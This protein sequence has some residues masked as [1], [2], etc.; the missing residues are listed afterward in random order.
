MDFGKGFLRHHH[1]EDGSARGDVP[2]ALPDAVGGGHA[3]ARVSLGRAHGRAC[4]Q[5]PAGIQELRSLGGQAPCLF[6]RAEHPGQDI[7]QLPAELLLRHQ[8]VELLYHPGV[9]VTGL[10]IDWEH[11]GGLAHAQHL[12]PRQPPV[13]V[14][15]QG[16]KERHVLHMLLPVQDG[17]IE[18]GDAPSLGNV[19]IEFLQQLPA[20][21]PGHGI[22]PGP[23]GHQQL[24]RRVKGHIAVHHTRK[25][26]GS[27]L[28]QPHP[29]FR[30]HVLRKAPVAALQALPDVFQAVSPDIVLQAVLPVP[31]PLRHRLMALVHQHGLDPGG[32]EFQA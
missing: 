2:R 21:L 10:G 3:G 17:L 24:T 7:P 1:G 14:S 23:E 6:T 19:E 12:F 30:L 29:V 13:D 16:G 27:Q 26:K 4:L 31:V 11:A 18:V 8:P 15:G 20:G 9:E 25:A 22:A 28:F 32:A 5:G